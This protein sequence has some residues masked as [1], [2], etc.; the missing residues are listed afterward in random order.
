MERVLPTALTE[1]GMFAGFRDALVL[2][3]LVALLTGALAGYAVAT[4][5]QPQVSDPDD[6]PTLMMVVDLGTDGD[7]RWRVSTTFTLTS[8][9]EREAFEDLAEDFEAGETTALGLPAVRQASDEASA[10]TGREMEIRGV[11]RNSSL[12]T[13]GENT[14]GR[15]TVAFTW[16]NF[17]RVDGD[18]LYVDDVFAASEGTAW[19][20]GLAAGE[21]FV[22]R[23]P[24]GYGVAE[25]SV[26]PES[27]DNRSLLRWTG[28]A[29][30]EESDLRAE[31]TGS[32]ATTG[33]ASPTPAGPQ[34]SV[35]WP[36]VFALGIG[37]GAVA[38]YLLARQRETLTTPTPASESPDENG[39][40]VTATRPAAE[41]GDDEAEPGGQAEPEDEG[42]DEESELDEELLSDEERVELLLEQNGGR[43]KQANIVRETG[44]SNAKVSQLLSSM[45][46][47]DRI[48]K[49]RIGRENLISFPDEDVTDITE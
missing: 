47:E 2:A 42:G 33:T 6:D 48:D 45:E 23:G 9:A 17:A 34:S 8:E 37:G 36:L 12:N 41:R 14:T 29:T 16:T 21:E 27:R 4:P 43:M 5:S 44:W 24:E 15:L 46:K 39:G 10:A 35:P 40:E 30:F 13:T 32:Q 31:F 49:L 20:P 7:A 18:R 38:V 28:P 1:K 25:A 26:A 3:L 11:E 22:L 19:L